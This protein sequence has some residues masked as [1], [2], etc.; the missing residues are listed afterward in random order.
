MVLSL[1]W[2]LLVKRFLA[3]SSNSREL[4]VIMA[5]MLA[6][7]FPPDAGLFRHFQRIAGLGFD[8]ARLPTT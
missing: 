1:G 6:A 7:C 4:T 8:F 5:F 2:N 3:L